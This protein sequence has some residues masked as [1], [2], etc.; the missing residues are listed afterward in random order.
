MPLPHP[1]MRIF[2]CTPVCFGGGEDFFCRDSGLLCRGLQQIGIDSRAVMPE[3][4]GENDQPDLIRTASANLESPKWWRSQD[5]DGVVLYAWGSPRY[6]NVARAIKLSGCFLILNQDNGGLVSPLAGLRAW[7][8]EQWILSGQGNGFGS[9]LRWLRLL[10]KGL[11]IGIVRTDVLR[12]MHLRHGDVI[13]C[14]S[15]AAVVHYQ[16]LCR[17]YGADMVPR[18]TLLPHAVEP[19]FRYDGSEKKRQV[20]CV[21][22]WEDELQKRPEFLMRVAAGL[23]SAD[24]D[25]CLLIAGGITSAMDS[26]WNSLPADQKTR[27]KMAGRLN[28]S[29][30]ARGMAES[31]IFYSPSAY[32]SFGI[33]AAEALC[34]GCSVV[35]GRLVSMASFEWF[36]AENSG[37]L[38]CEDRVADHVMALTR[39]LDAW[40]QGRR[41]PSEISQSWCERLHADHVAE[42]VA[43]M[44]GSARGRS[45]QRLGADKEIPAARR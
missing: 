11:S 28:R 34:C 21:G 16:R 36:T 24:R 42:N 44:V 41:A 37:Q 9:W 38:A 6:R 39:E 45:I 8:G 25:A 32:E 5:L 23:L 26:W 10:A 29:A 17:F 4:S 18:V 33:A 27:V 15:P 13:A 3:P 40:Q 14:V 22:R 30:L 35:A 19:S 20:I 12:A 43:M 31:M 2:T 7:F 1:A